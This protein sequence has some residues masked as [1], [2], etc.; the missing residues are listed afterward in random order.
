MISAPYLLQRYNNGLS[1]KTL[2]REAKAI[3]KF[4]AFV[5]SRKIDFLTR[6]SKLGRLHIGEIEELHAYLCTH[7]ET[8]ELLSQATFQHYFSTAQRFIEFLF[9][10]YQSRI[11]VTNPEKLQASRTILESMKKSFEINKH[12]PHNGKTKERVGLTPKLQC[13]FFAA[14]DPNEGNTLNPF[15]SQRT[16]WRNYCLFLTLILGGNRKGETLGLKVRDFQLIGNTTTERYFEII[17]RDRTFD[18]YPRKEIPSVK[19]NGRKVTLSTEMANIFEYYITEVRPKFKDAKKNEYMFLSNRDGKPL[20]PNTPN[21]VI[22]EISKHHPQLKGKLSPHILRNTF[23]DL[24]STSLDDK[25]E[26]M[27]PIRKQQIKTTMQ[28]Y[29]GGWAAGSNMVAHYSKGSIQAHV[30]KLQSSVQSN[31]LSKETTDD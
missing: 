22:D 30:A 21:Q 13:L 7:S 17:K 2:E 8:G 31:I 15:K 24:L 18:G 12:S 20:H 9:N 1:L 10:Y 23:H 19:T 26:G 25:F 28:E 3:R 29:A 14:I 16:R 6:L 4:Y 5:I 27:G 11:S